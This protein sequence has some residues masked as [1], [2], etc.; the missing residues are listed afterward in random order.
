MKPDSAAGA[1]AGLDLAQGSL[2]C[3]LGHPLGHREDPTR[4]LVSA[5][6]TA[7]HCVN[8]SAAFRWAGPYRPLSL[9]A[10]IYQPVI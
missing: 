3:D 6:D 10:L 2:L 5:L 9:S 8:V 1:R 7:K 4:T